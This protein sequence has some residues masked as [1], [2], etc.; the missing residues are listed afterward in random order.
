MPKKHVLLLNPPADKL[1]Q[2]DNYCSFSSKAGYYWP[3]IDLLVQSGILSGQCEISVIDAIAAGWD[4]RKTRGAIEKNPPDAVFFVTGTASWKQQFLFLDDLKKSVPAVMVGSGGNLFFEAERFLKE[5]A[6]LDAILLDYTSDALLRYLGGKGG[7]TPDLA[8]RTGYSVADV[9]GNGGGKE[10]S[11]APPRHD[12][13]PLKRYRLP[14]AKS[15]PFTRML[16]SIGCPY[17]C[18]FCL[19]SQMPYRIRRIDNV[20]Q[21]LHALNGYGIHQIDFCDPTF[22][23]KRERT[24][25]LCSAIS[26]AGLRLHW[27]CNSR[28]DAVDEE[29]LRAMKRAGCHIVFFGVESGNQAMLDRYAKGI[30][31]EAIRRAFTLCRDIGMETLAYFII[32]LPGET[33]ESA[34]ETIA[35]AHDLKPDY[36]SFDLATPD[37]GTPLMQEAKGNGRIP[38][39]L[40]SF[41]STTYPVM[42]IGTLTK[43]EVWNLR[44]RAYAGFYLRPAYVLGRL[45]KIR[46]MRE[47]RELAS[48]G[49]SLILGMFRKG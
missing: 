41:D 42:E 31:I 18:R 47:M 14:H 13:F 2:N 5:H 27:S 6:F 26:S 39:S 20:V 23:V 34:E 25:D 45:L 4:A 12:L 38:Q 30:T 22:V 1:Y 9:R 33:R 35:L 40:D 49:A 48:M 28:V 24:L 8:T 44:N 29:C 7:P 11:Y 46:S 32:G 3:S 19:T 17:R 16:T 37:Y 43:D 36:V 10:I 15:F 21:E